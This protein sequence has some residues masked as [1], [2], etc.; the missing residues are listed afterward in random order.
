MLKC[1]VIVV[2]PYEQ[3]TPNEEQRN[4][5]I[6]EITFGDYELPRTPVIPVGDSS[7]LCNHYQDVV[8]ITV[9]IS[10]S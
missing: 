7:K 1:F 9:I 10:I 4:N 6:I 5:Q 2:A 8:D 3:Y